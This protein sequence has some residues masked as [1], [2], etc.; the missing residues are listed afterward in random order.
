VLLL[1]QLENFEAGGI[2][3][4]I[5]QE[6]LPEFLNMAGKALVLGIVQL[7]ARY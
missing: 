1:N 3:L 5:V 2:A 7:E 6:A 4:R